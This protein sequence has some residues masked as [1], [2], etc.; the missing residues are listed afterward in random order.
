LVV[1]S[2]G[3]KKFFSLSVRTPVVGT[4]S[5]PTSA[6]KCIIR[7]MSGGHK[8][9]MELVPSSFEWRLFKDHMHFY[10]LLGLIPIGMIISAANL[11]IG[12]AELADIPEVYEPKHWEY[13]RSPI[14]RFISRY[15]LESQEE[16]YERNMH[17]LNIEQD[18]LRM[19]KLQKKIELLI[20]DAEHR[21]DS[22]RWYYIPVN[23]R[24]ALVNKEDKAESEQY[25]DSIN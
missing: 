22:R 14:S 8:R 17:F 20:G 24:T 9:T 15:I 6:T 1:L 25:S 7:F 4:L 18:K 19:R 5:L 23:E 3:A 11:F 2:N 12:Q 13:Y 10:F 16:I 21:H